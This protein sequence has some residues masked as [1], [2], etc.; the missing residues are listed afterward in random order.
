MAYLAFIFD[1]I[2][3]VMGIFSRFF[4]SDPEARAFMNLKMDRYESRFDVY[5][6]HAARAAGLKGWVRMVKMSTYRMAEI[7]VEGP[8]GKI[9]K[10]LKKLGEGPLDAKALSAE[11]Q[12][13]IYKKEFKDF[14]IRL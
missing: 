11:I 14:R 9:E 8:K 12:W 6:E 7:E 4:G 3:P 13:K 5:A 10:F 1:R 2:C